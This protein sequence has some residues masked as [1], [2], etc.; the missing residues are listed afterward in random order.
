MTTDRR[1]ERH[2]YY[3]EHKEWENESAHQY[4]QN[5]QVQIRRRS[6]LYR[7]NNLERRKES[8]KKS[9]RNHPGQ[10]MSRNHRIRAL[11]LEHYGNC[12]ACCGEDHAE[13]LCVD[14]VKGDGSQHRK[15]MNFHSGQQIYRWL[16]RNDFPDGFRLLCWNCNASLGIRGY[17]PHHPEDRRATKNHG[18]QT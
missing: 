7:K 15:I 13:F 8:E 18:S 4:Y 1:A 17:C 16:V 3:L 6:R 2:K 9:K 10:E 5:H 12:C 14:H 11:V